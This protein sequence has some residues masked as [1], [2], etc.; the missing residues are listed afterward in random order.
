MK[1]GIDL[2]DPDSQIP[3][4]VPRQ[5]AEIRGCQKD[6]RKHGKTDQGKPPVYH[7]KENRNSGQQEDVFEENGNNGSQQLVEVLNIVCNACNK[8]AHR[9]CRKKRDTTAQKMGKQ[10]SP[11]IM[12]D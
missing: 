8:T 12:Y 5:A 1:P 9:I 11:Q 10:I 7:K 3:E 4:N 6:N 2:G